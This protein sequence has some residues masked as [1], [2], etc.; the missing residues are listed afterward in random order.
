MVEE[1]AN[2]LDAIQV[3]DRKVGD[4]IK[5]L[6]D[7]GLLENTIVFFFS[8]HGMRLTRHK[9]FLYDG[10]LH[11]PLIIADYSHAHGIEAGS[12]DD[13]LINGIDLG[14]TALAL[15]GIPLPAYMEGRDIFDDALAPRE[16]VIATRDRCD[17]TIDRIRAVRSKSF[18]YIRNL[19]TDRPYMQP[20]YMDVD[21]VELVQ[22]MRQL[23]AENKLDS[24]QARFFSKARPGEELYDLREDPFEINNLAG[25]PD[26]AEVLE[27]YAAVLDQWMVDTDDKGQYPEDPEGLKLMLG[28]WGKYAI[29]PEYDALREEYPDLEGSLWAL[30]S[31][32]WK[33]ITGE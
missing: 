7:N 26:Y 31:E 22:V 4:I 12:R 3:T 17:F 21:S 29:N 23:Y 14:P 2:H 18:K 15:A 32:P 25:D 8:D 20:T 9:Q 24:I 13:K 30:K 1:Y 16:Y 5:E 28:I 33:K 6:S 19:K 11:V 27:T 10:G